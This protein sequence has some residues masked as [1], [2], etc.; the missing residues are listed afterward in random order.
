MS[1]VCLSVTFTYGDHIILEYFK[2]NFT[3]EY[4]EV[5]AQIDPNMGD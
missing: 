3:A 2:N 1:S 4:L 5:R